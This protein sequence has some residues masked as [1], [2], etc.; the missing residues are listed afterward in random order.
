MTL[1]FS[2]DRRSFFSSL[3]LCSCNRMIFVK[4]QGRQLEGLL[5][6][7]A[8]K[9]GLVVTPIVDIEKE[10]QKNHKLK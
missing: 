7:S 2:C 10:G 8:I 3:G 4:W 1:S 5:C 9:L 6:S